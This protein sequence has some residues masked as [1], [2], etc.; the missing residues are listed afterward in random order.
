MHKLLDVAK[1]IADS[2][3]LEQISEFTKLQ[4]SIVSQMMNASTQVRSAY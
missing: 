4:A 3:R 1:K 2:A